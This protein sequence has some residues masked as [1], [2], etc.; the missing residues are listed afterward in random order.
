MA[1]ASPRADRG[2]RHYEPLGT[3]RSRSTARWSV[4]RVTLLDDAA[5]AMLPRGAQGA[6]Q[7]IEDAAVLAKCLE[8]ADRNDIGAALQRYELI[9][10]PRATAYMATINCCSSFLVGEPLVSAGF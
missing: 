10:K 1:S 9:R 7:A 8:H 2:R 3:L 5:H 4:R 6:V